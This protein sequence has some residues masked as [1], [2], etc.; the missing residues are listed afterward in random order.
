M[1]RSSGY[2]SGRRETRATRTP[3]GGAA[4]S[5]EL[6]DVLLRSIREYCGEVAADALAK[7]RSLP[8]WHPDWDREVN[9]RTWTFAER[10]KSTPMAI[11]AARF[12]G[13]GGS[14]GRRSTVSQHATRSY[15]VGV[16]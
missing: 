7:L 15:L 3:V 6:R 11:K 4:P 8:D 5:A 13:I 14:R 9:A 16:V 2:C 1:I 10:T 12:P